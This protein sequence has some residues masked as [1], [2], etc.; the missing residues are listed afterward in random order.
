[1]SDASKA[2][3]TLPPQYYFTLIFYFKHLI[4]MGIIFYFRGIEIRIRKSVANIYGINEG[5]TIF[6]DKLVLD[7]T[8]TNATIRELCY[9]SKKSQN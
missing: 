2:S 5:S 9:Q 6:S 8:K 1:V 4:S 3:D 7:I